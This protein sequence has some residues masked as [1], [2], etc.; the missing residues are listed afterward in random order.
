MTT[1]DLD[2][3]THTDPASSTDTATDPVPLDPAAVEAFAQQVAGLITGGAATAMMVVGDRLGLYAELAQSGAV[4]SDQLASRTGCTERHLREWLAQ[5]AA[6]GIL[7]HDPAHRTFRL[8]PERAAVLAGDESPASLIGAAPIV[9]GMHRGLDRLVDAYRTGA[10]IPWGEQDETVFEAIERFFGTAYRSF[11]LP[12]WLPALDGVAEKLTRGVD[13]LDVGCGRAAPLLLMAQAF[14]AS[15]FHGIDLHAGS[16]AVARE[17][18]ADAGLTDRVEVEVSSCLD[19]P[20][21]GY[22][23]IT[24]YDVL[25]DLGDPTAA[26]AYAREALAADGTVMVVEERAGDDLAETLRTVPM[27]ALNYAASAFLCTPN[28][29][30]QPGAIALG[31]Q[32]GARAVSQVLADAGF[33]R[34]RR[35]VDSPFHTV[36]EARL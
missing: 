2:T 11:L 23:L 25:H 16:V 18:I 22:D 20:Q 17:R 19:Y 28:S 24:F 5:Q 32:A 34:V 1:S 36:L 10:G 7:E 14:P 35:A 33:T 29:L 30:S 6:T 3:T 27:A 15:R 31:S 13:V 4:T 26:A 8:P 12:Q 9:T 21:R